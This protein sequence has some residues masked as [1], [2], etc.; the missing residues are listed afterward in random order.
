MTPPAVVLARRTTGVVIVVNVAV[1]ALVQG[2]AALGE[3]DDDRLAEQVIALLAAGF[4]L[5]LLAQV[6]A[7]GALWSEGRLLAQMDELERLPRRSGLSAA[8]SGAAWLTAVLGVPVVVASLVGPGPGEGLRV[9]GIGALLDLAGLLG[10]VVV[11]LLVATPVALL[12]PASRTSRGVGRSSALRTGTALVLL[13]LLPFGIAL[14]QAA[15]ELG[16]RR[17]TGVADVV[18]AVLGQD[19]EGDGPQLWLM[20]AR[21]LLAVIALGVL[22]V[23]VGGIHASRRSPEVPE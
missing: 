7:V 9:A 12:L 3:L 14:A 23:L 19:V 4:V 1:V 20:A 8:R 2:R 22:L 11:G 5:G 6:A 13:P 18:L 17:S 10:G 21:V 15:P 16:P